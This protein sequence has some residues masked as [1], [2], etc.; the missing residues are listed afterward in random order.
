MLVATSYSCWRRP[1]RPGCIGGYCNPHP[2]R[3]GSH[4]DSSAERDA[5]CHR[6]TLRYS[7]GDDLSQPRSDDHSQFY[8][9]DYLPSSSDDHSQPYSHEHGQPYSLGNSHA[10]TNR[11]PDGISDTCQSCHVSSDGDANRHADS[12][13]LCLAVAT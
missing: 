7:D 8:N 2:D 4:W 1:A 13:R 9:G 11:Q 3:S 6:S 5:V 12:P 10:D